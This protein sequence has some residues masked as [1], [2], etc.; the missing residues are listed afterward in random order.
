MGIPHLSI[1]EPGSFEVISHCAA[2]GVHHDDKSFSLF[3]YRNVGGLLS[4]DESLY[5]ESNEESD[6]FSERGLEIAGFTQDTMRDE[7]FI[8]RDRADNTP[9]IP[10]ANP[11]M[12][13]QTS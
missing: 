1:F 2:Q 8:N 11:V 13:H 7:M 10:E 5:N 9:A 4:N 3:P 6:S 12:E